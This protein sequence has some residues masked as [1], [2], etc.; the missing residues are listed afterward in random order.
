MANEVQARLAALKEFTM[1]YYPAALA[2]SLLVAVGSS[3]GQASD[4]TIRYLAQEPNMTGFAT[5]EAFV[6]AGL[7]PGDDRN[8]A[9]G[10]GHPRHGQEGQRRHGHRVRASIGT[11]SSCAGRPGRM[12]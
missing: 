2:L 12:P 9:R 11:R 10:L 8:R 5:V 1:R 6:E 3:V 7:A 4:Y